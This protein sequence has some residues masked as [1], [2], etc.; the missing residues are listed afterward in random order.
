MLRSVGIPARMAVGFAQ[1]TPTEI[2]NEEAGVNLL[3]SNSFTVRKNNAHAWPEVYFPDIGWIE[4]EPTANQQALSRP[5]ASDPN[6]VGITPPLIDPLPLEERPLREED[7]TEGQ[8]QPAEPTRRIS[9][10]LILI[11]LFIALSALA[12]FFGRRYH[13]AERVPVLVRA[14]FERSGTRVPGWVIRWERW[15]LLSPIAKAFQSINFGLRL[16]K[17]PVPLHSTPA[18]RAEALSNVLPQIAE[19]IKVLLDEHQ[20]SLYTSRTADVNRARR[21]ALNIRIQALVAF[22]RHLFIGEYAVRS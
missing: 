13:I 18:E 9:P 16:L 3:L 1:G 19:P 8:Q 7:P 12:V 21:S 14:S 20:T 5:A 22:I 15:T 2:K 4:F 17:Q 10:S 11:P 6:A